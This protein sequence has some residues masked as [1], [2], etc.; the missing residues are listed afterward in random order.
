MLRGLVVMELKAI[1]DRGAGS[2]RR[3]FHL[4]AQLVETGGPRDSV[5]R[6]IDGVG[7]VLPEKAWT[8]RRVQRGQ[9]GHPRSIGLCHSEGL[10]GTDMESLT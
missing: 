2:M 1:P 10:R 5:L 3:R 9:R 8:G 7:S 6:I 4:D